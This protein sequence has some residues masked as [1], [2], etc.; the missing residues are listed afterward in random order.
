MNNKP[1]T[2]EQIEADIKAILAK[3]KRFK[4]AEAKICFSDKKE[5]K[6]N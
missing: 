3:D 4:D 2:K 6:P 1:K 5:R